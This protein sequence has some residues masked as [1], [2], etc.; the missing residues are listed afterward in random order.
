M[1]FFL[2]GSGEVGRSTATKYSQNIG[3]G[4]G[5]TTLTGKKIN[6]TETATRNRKPDRSTP[7]STRTAP[8]AFHQDGGVKWTTDGPNAKEK[9]KIGF[10]NVRTMF[11]TGKLAE[12]TIEMRRYRIDIMGISES[13]WTDSGRLTTN[14]GETIL[15]SGRDDGNH[16]QG[17]AVILR[18]DLEKCLMEWKP[19]NSRL[20]KVRLKGKHNNTTIIQCYAPTND[21]S[22]N[23]KED[24]Y[25]QLQAE[26]EAAPRHDLIIVMG[27]LNAKVGTDNTDFEG[28]MGKHGIGTRNDNGERLTE[29]CAMNNLII[30][31]TLFQH[32]DIHKLTWNSPNGR[33]KNQID[34]LLINGKW[35]SSLLDVKV[36]RGADVGSDHHL[37][38]ACIK[39]KLKKSSNTTNTHKRFDVDQLKDN[40]IRSAFT[41]SLKNRFHALQNFSEEETCWEVNK[42]WEQVVDIYTKSSK[43]NLGHLKRIKKKS[44]IQQETLDTMEERRQVKKKILQTKSARLKERHETTYKELNTKVKTLA[45]RDKR[46]AMENMAMEA[47][48]AAMRGEQRRMYNIM[49]QICGKFKG[50]YNGPIKDKQGKLLVTQKEQEERWT[51]HFN[52]I[53]NRPAPDEM[54]DIPEAVEDLDIDTT[55]PTKE[56]IIR[57]IRLLKNGKAP[58]QDNLNAELFRADP[59]LSASILQPLF[60]IIW[61]GEKIPD[62]W[63]KG[64]IVK[65]PKKGSLNDCNNW[66]G[67]TLLS[68]PSKI[69]AKIIIMRMSEAVDKLL[70]KEQAGFRKG[71][72]CTDQIFA[73]RNIIEQCAEW[74]REM[75]VNFVDF[76]KAFD[77]IHRESLWCIL[78]NYGIPKK[79]VTLIKSFYTNFRCTVNKGNDFFDVK[80]GV[81]QGCVMSA[82]LFNVTIDWVMRKTTEK[83]PRGIR[84][85]LFSRLEDLD[86][87]DDLALLSHTHNDM[88]EKTNELNKFSKQ[89]GL[90]INERKTETM[91]M[92]V[93]SPKHIQLNNLN[94]QQTEKFTYLGSI[95]RPEG[96]TKEDINNRLGKARAAFRNMDKIWRSTQF[97]KKTKL[98]LYQSCIVST[99]L[100]GSECWRMTETDIRKLRSFHTTCLRKIQGIYWP[101]KISNE[102]LLIGCGQQDMEDI[103]TR[104]RWNWIGHVLRREPDSIIR[105]ALH[106]TPEGKRK[107]GRPRMTWRRTVEKEIKDLKMTWGSLTRLAQDR[108]KWKSFVAALHTPRCNRS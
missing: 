65:I 88:Q 104:R 40:K 85:S 27:D 11:E 59:E 49:K 73:L 105:T 53:L 33:D 29:F 47:E 46:N 102:E 17:V 13:R 22:E 67:I 82:I 93:T 35:R 8:T 57:A 26:T 39:L 43:E 19:V 36:K 61:E 23:D 9:T 32:R 87:A 77:S 37:V 103:I 68:I 14:T 84:W 70:R 94:L 98:K 41:V 95:I 52:E 58:G 86:F 75:H 96:G 92:N 90:K 3:F 72:R 25:M 24:F 74:Q 79:L 80:T 56:E 76:E 106:W 81:R 89:I 83:T 16:Q 6:V 21:S 101:K 44:W 60:E 50:N 62:D 48:E 2:N 18:K 66:R 30:G 38:T 10:W 108:Q 28:V 4:S 69:M 31:G 15:Y 91:T 78:R 20:L 34:H 1:L 42:M 107:K 71:R 54:A 97:N 99:L 45:R 7:G 63:N 64:M 55:S 51:Q 12:V 100:Y 5:L